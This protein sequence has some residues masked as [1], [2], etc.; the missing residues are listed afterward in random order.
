MFAQAEVMS[1]S[2]VAVKHC[3]AFF[4]LFFIQNVPFLLLFILFQN[5][6]LE[7]I[8]Q[9]TVRKQDRQLTGGDEVGALQ[10]DV[11]QVLVGSDGSHEVPGP[12]LPQGVVMQHQPLH[13]AVVLQGSTQHYTCVWPHA[14]PAHIQLLSTCQVSVVRLA[15]I[16]LIATRL[17]CSYPAPVNMSGVGC[18]ACTN[19]S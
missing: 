13:H 5:T 1:L 9:K 8:Q 7:I 17:S 2:L 4:C 6:S 3:T 19:C 18:S 11:L 14:S 15:H 12:H 16:A 10:A